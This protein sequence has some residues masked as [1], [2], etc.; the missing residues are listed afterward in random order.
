MQAS[1]ARRCPQCSAE[2][3]DDWR[4]CPACEYRLTSLASETKTAFT[5]AS[6]PPVST[7][8]EEGRFRAGTVLAGRYRVMSLLGKGGMGEVY[9]AHDLI[10]SQQ[11]AL[12]FL[13]GSH[14]S[15]AGLAR[16]RNEVR[17]ARQVS[18]PNVCR[19]YDIG[20]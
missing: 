15:E 14:V 5:A 13:A 9:R 3:H 8:I 4:V 17:V 16:F 1:G 6:T 10:L 19:V 11:V 7:G 20:S 18:H 2:I 12:K